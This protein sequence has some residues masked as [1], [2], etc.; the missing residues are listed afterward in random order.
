M[1]DFV[2]INAVTVSLGLVVAIS[3]C[4]KQDFVVLVLF[5]VEHVVAFLKTNKISIIDS[6]IGLFMVLVMSRLSGMFVLS[7]N[8][9]NL[10]VIA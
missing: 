4:I 8:H 1:H 3:A 6:F 5:R 9:D 10:I 2:D 7:C